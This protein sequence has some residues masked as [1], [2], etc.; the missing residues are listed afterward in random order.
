M[1]WLKV[2][3]RQ[4]LLYF[5]LV[6]A[7][8]FAIDALLKSDLPPPRI[9]KTVEQELK[10]QL[11]QAFGRPPTV[12][13][14]KRGLEEWMETELLFREARAYGLHENDAVIRAHLASKLRYIVREREFVSPPTEAELREHFQ[15]H[16]S[17]YLAPATYDLSHA[18]L[19]GVSR[20]DD[21]RVRDALTLLEK[22]AALNSVGDHFPRGPVFRRLPR[23]ILERALGVELGRALTQD[24]LQQW[25]RIAGRRGMHLV[26]VEAINAKASAFESARPRVLAD[27][28][29]G[30]QDE[31]VQRFV[32]ELREKYEV[33]GAP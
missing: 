32:A 16:Q 10:V 1:S 13:E 22:G 3:G 12:D 26:R 23:D 7:A 4:P 25:Q 27:V 9:T 28:V 19:F 8:V 14:L 15:A 31:V 33:D 30:K 20:T 21:P 24:R 29:A 11:E 5:V 2:V 6:G 18:F 17:R